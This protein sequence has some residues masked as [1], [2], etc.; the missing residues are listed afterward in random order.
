ME[1][2]S[3][4]NNF[5]QV[6]FSCFHYFYDSWCWKILT[7]VMP[8]VS[9]YT[10]K[11]L[12]WMYLNLIQYFHKRLEILTLSKSYLSICILKIV[13]LSFPNRKKMYNSLF[14]RYGLWRTED[15]HTN[16]IAW[17][18][19]EIPGLVVVLLR[20]TK[21]ILKKTWHCNIM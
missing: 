15:N 9:F 21:F 11:T 4:N 8:L 6:S 14:F 18:F 7:N 2:N 16:K 10:I 3:S 17:Y 19:I 5:H 1:W 20:Q 13:S 12:C